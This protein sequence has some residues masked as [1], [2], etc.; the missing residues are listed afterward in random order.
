MMEAVVRNEGRDIGLEQATLNVVPS[1]LHL[2]YDLDFRTWRVDDIAPTLT[3]SLLS[4]L[5]INIRLRGRPV[6]PREPISF[7]VEEG[8]WGHGRA[9]ARPDAPGPSRDGGIVPQMQMG[10]VEAKENKPCEQGENDPDQTLLEPDPEE[11]AAV[12]ISDDNEA[13]LPID[14]P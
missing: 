13:D 8:L 5:V 4:W 12:M 1:G 6:V 3:S 14:M 10:E 11:V 2:D 7:K 9:P